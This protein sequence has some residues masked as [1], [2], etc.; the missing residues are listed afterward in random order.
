M[1]LMTSLNIGVVKYAY[2][3]H[4]TKKKEKNFS[5]IIYDKIFKN[6]FLTKL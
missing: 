6:G 4:L 1:V 5:T 2:E 3:Y